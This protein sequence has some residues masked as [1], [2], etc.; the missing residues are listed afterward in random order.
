V[1]T[2]PPLITMMSQLIASPSI[3]S[4]QASWD[5]SNKK[6]I[7]LLESWLSSLGF[8]CEVMAIP[9]RPNNVNLIATI[10]HGEGGLVLSGHTDT[11]PYDQGRWQSDPFSLEERDNKLYGL[12]SCDM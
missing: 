5:Q 12:G 8:S 2:P 1:N 6:V 10:G 4:S 3:S 11:V 7:E 9:N